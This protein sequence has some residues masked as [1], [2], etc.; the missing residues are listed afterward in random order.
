MELRSIF[1]S[2]I[3]LHQEEFPL[4]LK[5]RKQQLPVNKDSIVT[6]T[7]IRR[8]GKSSLL[9]L[10]INRLLQNGVKPEQILYIGFDDERF[11]SMQTSNFDEILQAY[12]EMYPTQSLKDVY[13]FFD[14]IQLI[15]GW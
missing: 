4:S 3:A 7:G 12:R 9:G 2:V 6:V 1:Q 13:M 10:T 15:E 8:C 5:E 11:A 14:E